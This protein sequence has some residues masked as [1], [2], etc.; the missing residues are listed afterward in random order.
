MSGI[1][2]V[3]DA[4]AGGEDEILKRRDIF[5]QFQSDAPLHIIDDA[6]HWV[7]YETPEVF[8]AALLGVLDG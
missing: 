2:G 7:M 6:G 5:R 4:T 8:E 1:W 3:H